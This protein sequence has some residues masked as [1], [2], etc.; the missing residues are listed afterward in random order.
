MRLVTQ[1]SA[2]RSVSTSS[3][4]FVHGMVPAVQALLDMGE[5]RTQAY[6]SR[7]AAGEATGLEPSKILSTY[8]PRQL[9]EV[10]IVHLSQRGR[11]GMVPV[12]E[13]KWRGEASR[14]VLDEDGYTPKDIPVIELETEPYRRDT[15]VK[16]IIAAMSPTNAVWAKEPEAYR[17]AM[18][19]LHHAGLN[20]VKVTPQQ[21]GE[22]LGR[23]RV[24]GWRTLRKLVNLG[25]WP[26]YAD[27]WVDFS[28][29]F[30]DAN[31]VWA[32][33]ALVERAKAAETVRWSVFTK[34]G[35]EVRDMAKQ[36][37]AMLPTLPRLEE[38][39]PVFIE[40]VGHRRMAVTVRYVRMLFEQPFAT[41][42]PV[43]I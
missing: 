6:I 33:E 26:L 2:D 7:D 16:A 10:G 41:G 30:Y 15:D 13:G 42:R 17:L 20:R 25:G 40:N 37:R 24:T 22:I 1:I 43:E 18:A 39:N 9:A 8:Y 14:W 4:R 19:L 34:A 3:V 5:H 36:W 11:Y 27:G 35:W 32:D 29:L 31:L 12:S 21:A 28:T 23:S 38:V